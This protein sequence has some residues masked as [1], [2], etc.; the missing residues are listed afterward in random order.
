MCAWTVGA[1]YLKT[2]LVAPEDGTLRGLFVSPGICHKLAFLLI[3]PVEILLGR[4]GKKASHLAFVQCREGKMT[5]HMMLHQVRHLIWVTT[6][7]T[8]RKTLHFSSNC[9]VL[10]DID[11]FR[12]P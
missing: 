2:S 12:Y 4:L 9:P 5:Y 6:Y 3:A 10:V 7:V 1:S 8:M 11:W